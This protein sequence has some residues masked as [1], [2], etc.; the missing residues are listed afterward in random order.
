MN[1]AGWFLSSDFSVKIP[2]RDYSSR[3][4]KDPPKAVRDKARLRRQESPAV[5]TMWEILKL[6]GV[7]R[8]DRTQNLLTLP[9]VTP[10]Y[11]RAKLD[12]YQHTFPASRDFSGLLIRAVERAEQA[13]DPGPN[14]HL[15]YCACSQCQVSR[16][17]GKTG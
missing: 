10:A 2:V 11:L 12:E 3:L 7:R 13:P 5:K 16:F 17:L 14:G 4:F 8:N 9:H 1:K 6:A 15:H